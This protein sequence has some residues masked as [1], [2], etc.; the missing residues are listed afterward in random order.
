MAITKIQS[1]SLN[2][3]D[4]YAFTGTVTGAGGITEAKIFRL[5]SNLTLSDATVTDITSNISAHDGTANG[6]IG[7]GITQSSGIFSFSNTG[8]YLIDANINYYVQNANRRV[9]VSTLKVTTNNSSYSIVNSS[10]SQISNLSSNSNTAN[11]NVGYIL[12]V[13]DTS[14][15]KCKFTAAAY[16]GTTYVETY[17]K[18]TFFRFIRLGDT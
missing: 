10:N 14:N 16:G 17:E 8:I 12:D 1:E 4:T 6:S 13:T 11:V 7:T 18:A 2:L 15:V 9:V 5:T 3:A